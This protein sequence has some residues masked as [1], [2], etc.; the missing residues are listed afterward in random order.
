[1]IE[2]PHTARTAG[3]PGPMASEAC[4]FPLNDSADSTGGEGVTRP[5]PE[6]ECYLTCDPAGDE[7][8]ENEDLDYGEY[9]EVG[10]IH[11]M[12][13]LLVPEVSKFYFAG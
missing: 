10:L 11:W 12:L 2:L 5:R 6:P 7:G 3:R 4:V 1:M 13:Q 9:S 8:G